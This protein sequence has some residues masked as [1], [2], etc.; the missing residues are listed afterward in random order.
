MEEIKN[1]VPSTGD[2][3][4]KK[5]DSNNTAMAVIAYII[6]FI[7]LLTDAKNDP[8]VKFHVKQGAVIFIIG[9]AAWVVMTVLPFLLPL[10]WLVQLFLLVMVVLG[11]VNVVNNKK[12]PLP[13]IGQ[14]ANQLKF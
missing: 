12:E 10:I 9:L 11:I 4:N 13:L 5:L 14:F 7:P 8:F 6:F 1:T 2:G 3:E